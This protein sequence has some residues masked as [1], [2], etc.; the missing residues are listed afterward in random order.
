MLACE[1]GRHALLRDMLACVEDAR[2]R[3]E[4][5]ECVNRFGNT[6]LHFAA[7]TDLQCVQALLDCYSDDKAAARR[8]VL[9]RCR[10]RQ[11]ALL[12][13]AAAARGDV[14]QLLVT[15]FNDA[16]L[17]FAVSKAGH[18]ALMLAVISRS[19]SAVLAVLNATPVD[20]QRSLVIVMYDTNVG[21]LVD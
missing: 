7:R 21:V 20:R 17:L 9:K 10:N 2:Q 6:A 4:L 13:A 5:V 14:V 15:R 18:S 3:C 11:T 16:D 8:A 12:Y 19:T 1:R